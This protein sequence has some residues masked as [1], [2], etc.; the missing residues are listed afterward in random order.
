MQ[1][2]ICR[3]GY[4]IERIEWEGKIK[5]KKNNLWKEMLRHNETQRGVGQKGDVRTVEPLTDGKGKKG[6]RN[7]VCGESHKE[8]K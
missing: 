5:S 6:G 1:R 8:L 2:L 7:L 4:E 3:K